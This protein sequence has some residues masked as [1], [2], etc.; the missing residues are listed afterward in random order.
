MENEK[1]PIE[2]R[3]DAEDFATRY[4]NNAHFEPSAW[5]LGIT[6]GQTDQ[7]QGPNVIIQHT[8]ITIPWSYAKILVYFLQLNIIGQ[9]IE[10]GHI[11]VP[12][13]IL[14]PPPKTLP[15]ETQKELK[16]PK[17]ALAAVH[18]LWDEF[19]EANPELK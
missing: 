8:A 16:H 3:R 11:K 17:E 2:Y 5:D 1:K 15:E 10:N 18:K 14:A 13:N 4:A 19:L 6:F 7:V 9:E 12:P